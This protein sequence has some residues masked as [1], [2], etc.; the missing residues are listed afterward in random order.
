MIRP[1]RRAGI[2]STMANFAATWEN[3]R[4]GSGRY[5]MDIRLT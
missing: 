3:E 2:G 5:G 4:I 1:Y